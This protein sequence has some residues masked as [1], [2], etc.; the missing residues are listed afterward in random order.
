MNNNNIKW[1]YIRYVYIV[2]QKTLWNPGSQSIFHEYKYIYPIYIY[3]IYIY[4]YRE[5]NCC[6]SSFNELSTLVS[7]TTKWKQTKFDLYPLIPELT[8]SCRLGFEVYQHHDLSLDGFQ[9][10]LSSSHMTIFTED[11]G[12]NQT[13]CLWIT[14][15]LS[16]IYLL[17]LNTFCW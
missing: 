5:Y 8:L 4:I 3:H 12:Y 2:L 7:D 16:Q 14:K 11:F 15:Y 6:H 1:I 10:R 13:V 17:F 9:S